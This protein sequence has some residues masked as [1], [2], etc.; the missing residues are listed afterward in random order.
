M[1]FKYKCNSNLP[2][3]AWRAL[4]KDGNIEVTHGGHVETNDSF[5]V[6]G[7]WSGFFDE[8]CFDS[9]Q[10]FC[11]TGGRI[12][13]DKVVFST[14]THITGGIYLKAMTDG[15]ICLSNSLYLLLEGVHCCLDCDYRY[16]ETDF[17][18]IMSGVKRYKRKIHVLS[19]TD[20]SVQEVK[21]YYF[22]NIVIKNDNTVKIYMK[23]SITPFTSFSDYKTR[24]I[25][26]MQS[27]ADNASDSGRNR[28]F[29]MVTT[30][31]K[32]YDAPCC[33]AVAKLVG[34]DTAVTFSQKGKYVNDCGTEIAKTLGYE[35]II[36]RDEKAFVSGTDMAEAEYLCTGELGA[37]ISMSAFDEEFRNRLVFSGCRGD[38][39]WNAE[40]ALCNGEFHFKDI[41]SQLGLS[42]KRLWLGAVFVPMPLFGASE[43]ESIYKISNSKEMMP[44]RMG[45]RY[46]R[47]IPR[48]IVEEM[49]VPREWFGIEKHGMGIYF[50]YDWLARIRSRLSPTSAESFELYVRNIKKEKRKLLKDLGAKIIFCMR[51]WKVYW[52]VVADKFHVKRLHID[53]E[54]ISSISNPMAARYLI[55]WA[56]D[57]MLQRYKRIMRQGEQ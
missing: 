26:T 40:N 39:V 36:E 52:N 56:G 7:A 12:R 15:G 49:G 3:L 50:H 54:K 22:R 32:G 25:D 29:E 28:K 53:K 14:P 34:C 31:S 18:T 57:I 19:E 37:H 9:S 1:N 45:N 2:P 27:M 21:V 16:Y 24:L 41:I 44:W 17:N 38:F 10:W 23:P 51:I 4:I 47:P 43:W 48:R 35:N 5:F 8:G 33:S 13:N 11:G 46:D 20:K 55:P 42:E 30:V 6:E